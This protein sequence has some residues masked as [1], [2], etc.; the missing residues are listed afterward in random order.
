[1]FGFG[2]NRLARHGS[3]VDRSGDVVAGAASHA[4]AGASFTDLSERLTARAAASRAAVA[5]GR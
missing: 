3:S 5:T 1:M 4:G 2:S